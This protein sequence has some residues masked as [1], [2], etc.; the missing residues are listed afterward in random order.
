MLGRFNQ[1]NDE[2]ASTGKWLEGW[3]NEKIGASG[4]RDENGQ[5]DFYKMV[6]EVGGIWDTLT[7]DEKSLF[8]QKLAGSRQASNFANLM[9]N[10]E[11]IQ[12]ATDTALNSTGSAARSNKAKMDSIEGR[13]AQLEASISDFMTDTISSGAIKNL[14][15]A[16][17]A[18][19][20][21]FN[22]IPGS[23]QIAGIG[24]V[25]LMLGTLGTLVP[26]MAKF[27]AGGALGGMAT[28]IGGLM[29]GTASIGN[30]ALATGVANASAG[31]ALMGGRAKDFL[32]GI[33]NTG[34][35]KAGTTTA[36]GLATT[37]AGAVS[38][39]AAIAPA[40]PYLAAIAA[41][42]GVL[43]LTSIARDK[44]NQSII[45]S[46]NRLLTLTQ[47][48]ESKRNTAQEELIRLGN[49]QL[50]SQLKTEGYTKGTKEYNE[51]YKDRAWTKKNFDEK[52]KNGLGKI[53]QDYNK[54]SKEFDQYDAKLSAQRT[55]LE[56][57]FQSY[58]KAVTS[59]DGMLG[60][61]R[62][63]LPGSEFTDNLGTA[64]SSSIAMNNAEQNTQYA[65][66]RASYYAG[67]GANGEYEK[68]DTRTQEYAQQQAAQSGYNA[69]AWA[70]IG[71]QVNELLNYAKVAGGAEGYEEQLN[72]LKDMG[73]E[74]ADQIG[75]VILNSGI[76]S[77]AQLNAVLTQAGVEVEDLATT[78]L[79]SGIQNVATM[80]GSNYSTAQKVM[81]DGTKDNPGLISKSWADWTGEDIA[82]LQS[83][84]QYV[85][86]DQFAGLLEAK[87]NGTNAEG[88]GFTDALEDAIGQ[89][90][91]GMFGFE[92]LAE[93]TP[94]VLAKYFEDWG[95]K[96]AKALEAA[97]K[98]VEN[99]Q[100]E[101]A[102]QDQR[103][104]EQYGEDIEGY[105]DYKDT[106][107]IESVAEGNY[108][109][110]VNALEY[111]TDTRTQTRQDLEWT[112][113]WADTTEGFIDSL[114]NM[115]VSM[116]DAVQLT[117]EWYSQGNTLTDENGNV[118]SEEAAMQNVMANYKAPIDSNT[119]ALNANTA[120][121]MANID[122]DWL[123][124]NGITLGVDENGNM[125]FTQAAGLGAPG[126]VTPGASENKEYDLN[127]PE[128]V[129]K[130]LDSVPNFFSDLAN[131]FTSGQWNGTN[132]TTTETTV[133]EAPEVTHE[134]REVETEVITPEIED[135]TA[136]VN[137]EA[138][139]ETP[140]AENLTG[141]I[142]YET[143]VETP[144]VPEVPDQTIG[145]TADTSSADAAL[146]GVKAEEDAIDTNKDIAITAT[147]QASG[148]LGNI[149][150]LLAGITNKN[151]TVTTTYVEEHYGGPKA[152]GGKVTFQ[153]RKKK[154]NGERH[155]D[156]GTTGR[157]GL[158]GTWLGDEYT[159]SGQTKPEL[160][161]T[162]DGNA[163]LAGLNGWEFENLP[164][165][166]QVYSNSD[167]KKLL[168]ER[169]AVGG[170]IGMLHKRTGTV[171]DELDILGG[172][173]GN[174]GGSNN[175]GKGK[176]NSGSNSG[177]NSSNSGGGSGAAAAAKTIEGYV[178]D[179][180]D[181][182]EEICKQFDTMLSVVED[183]ID[184]LE[185][186]EEKTDTPSEKHF[187]LLENK[188][189][190]L[191]RYQ[192]EL[193]AQGAT[194]ENSSDYRDVLKQIAELM[195]D[196][197]NLRQK[198]YEHN[199][200]VFEAERNQM[201]F[202]G[203]NDPD[204]YVN[205][206]IASYEKSRQSALEQAEYLMSQ[207]YDKNSDEVIDLLEEANGYTED[208]EDTISDSTQRLV[209]S[210]NKNFKKTESAYDYMI[211]QAEEEKEQLDKEQARSDAL[212][213]LESERL[214]KEDVR[215][216]RL[217]RI[218]DAAKELSDVMD[219]R[220]RVMTSEGFTWDVD[221][222]AYEQAQK[223]YTDTMADIAR[224]VRDE[225]R[226]EAHKQERIDRYE[227]YYGEGSYGE[228]ALAT[229]D[230]TY[231]EVQKV[232][233]EQEKQT[234]L[235]DKI[236]YEQKYGNMLASE[237]LK[238]ASSDEELSKYTSE[239]IQNEV[240]GI[241]DDQF[242]SIKGV[243]EALVHGDISEAMDAILKERGGY[244]NLSKE[245]KY[246]FD[247]INGYRN[248]KIDILGNG[249]TKYNTAEDFQLT[250]DQD[251]D[252]AVRRGIIEKGLSEI[253]ES[254]KEVTY[255]DVMNL[256]N[257]AATYK[258]SAY[259]IGTGKID[260]NSKTTQTIMDNQSYDVF[261]D[262]QQIAP[263]NSLAEKL[264]SEVN[265]FTIHSLNVTA[266]NADD[267][268][269]SLQNYART[270][271]SINTIRK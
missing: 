93:M 177:S 17:N 203:R 13:K 164:A 47:E 190:I 226:E 12:S 233:D 214:A 240:A 145:I 50:E 250:R 231:A 130:F 37:S 188:L 219:E 64:L 218:Q 146:N 200:D 239:F 76:E 71:T 242:G 121:I 109:S 172:S 209:E 206:T 247:M 199:R 99:A 201:E 85:D 225:N 101:L 205:Q 9:Q 220:V 194:V 159:G 23:S 110:A 14:L 133:D 138:N 167:T 21:F 72:W 189:D 83:A 186:E 30:G 195:Q 70:E 211:W 86:E 153:D 84:L 191:N 143:N 100:E 176:S 61:I 26:A 248:Q 165:G 48:T 193:E 258:N 227:Q 216:D 182:L 230:S 252:K 1:I 160:V 198:Q 149:V 139:M 244:N 60:M 97:T 106:K 2:S 162:P 142:D 25:T 246:W 235:Q 140:E 58:A 129:K 7:Q 151:V 197:I 255:K 234:H 180:G 192:A 108:E 63:A 148:I 238:L 217:Q 257:Q 94:E 266:N 65:A 54:A 137:Y 29:M 168:G 59:A 111:T 90:L 28:S 237:A 204:K 53:D 179:I 263:R 20:Q 228:E 107:A 6:Q 89:N 161:V 120:A 202:Q 3:L 40:L 117:E 185:Y 114:N 141:E 35:I 122:S 175:S 32:T 112:G 104:R 80:L 184:L 144:E 259:D 27:Y 57:N 229:A 116:A 19:V 207:G 173:G 91:E 42:V 81:G 67:I 45:E 77:Q 251:V 236:L 52:Y 88:Q 135:Q 128:P 75:Q 154:F 170:Y 254:G 95:V 155:A 261:K 36:Q 187:K 163:H 210:I 123:T 56:A 222:Q 196:E 38:A 102:A 131:Y 51:A 46:N 243:K 126:T 264:N 221:P 8:S 181:K 44:N 212:Y 74:Q 62:D 158:V 178:E 249:A 150:G 22:A 127:A 87:Y 223:N 41:T 119:A 98:V 34:A 147:D 79:D 208:I 43:K 16:A 262:T 103:M 115:G 267:L 11:G 96:D 241:L 136:T 132:K 24:A 4:Y 31:L 271:L 113:K 49:D 169:H 253:K 245:E 125:T 260:L 215:I 69:D 5:L 183:S 92:G 55:I 152:K 10:L 232:K 268:V 166:T 15:S 174:S 18:M 118:L 66:A 256:M 68:W 134:T 224:E 124:N 265:Q 156:G 157:S 73:Y 33:R 270:T 213:D 269:V 105:K 39:G 82:N 171:T 78:Y